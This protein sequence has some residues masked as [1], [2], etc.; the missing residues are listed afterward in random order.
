MKKLTISEFKSLIK[1]EAQKLQRRTLLE[2]ERKTLLEELK[3]MGMLNEEKIE[4]FFNFLNQNP[5]KAS[6]AAAFYTAPVKMNKFIMTDGGKILNPM[7]DKLFKH[8]RFLFKWEDT[9]NRAMERLGEKNGMEHTP[10]KRSGTFEKVDGYNMLESGKSGL[11]LPIIPTGSESSYSVLENGQWMPIAKEE[12]YKY[13]PPRTDS[14]SSF[15]PEFR[16]LIV[17]RIAKIKAGGNE[18]SNPGFIYEYLG[19][20]K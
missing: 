11:Y 6:Q 7:I 17:D 19:P 1:E 9:F 8:T 4:D 16:A 10:G 13:L 12:V 3:E 18:W 15:K 14:S 5:Q 2:S 20:G